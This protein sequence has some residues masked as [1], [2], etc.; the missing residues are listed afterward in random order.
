MRLS[1]GG[2]LRHPRPRRACAAGAVRAAA[3][4]ALLERLETRQL[5]CFIHDGVSDGIAMKTDGFAPIPAAAAAADAAIAAA[6]AGMPDLNSRPAAPAA[7]YL[8]FDGDSATSTTAY[9]D[10]ADAT[11]F[12]PAEA[13]IITRAWE[14]M[15]TYF[16]VFDVNIT[17]TQPAA[18][19]PTAWI[20]I[21]NNIAG[22]YSEVGPFPNTGSRAHSWAYSG[23]AR[24]RVSGIAHEIGHNFGLQHQSDFNNLGV[25]TREYSEGYD[26]LHG[27]IMG[28]DVSQN[29]HKWFIGHNSV[30]AT[31]LQDDLTL[32]ANKIKPYQPV[33]GDGYRV[34]DFAD[35]IAAATALTLTGTMFSGAG[36]IERSPDVDSFSFTVGSAAR[37]TQITAQPHLNSAVD[38]KL[39]LYA[40]DG[41]LV[42]AAD[43]AANAQDI[44]LTLQPGQYYV[45]LSSHG[46]YGDVGMYDVA[47]NALP[48]GW[49]QQD[50]GPIG[51]FGGSASYDAA[52]GTFNIR[53]N[54]AL[55]GSIT[56]DYFRYYFQTLNGDGSI[57]ARVNSIVTEQD[58]GSAGI[59]VRETLDTNSKYAYLKVM[60]GGGLRYDVRSATGS[61]GNLTI[62]P[63][64]AA[65]VWLRLT[66]AGTSLTASHS[67]N[68]VNWTVIDTRTL[69]MNSSV[70]VGMVVDS[71]YANRDATA[72]FSNV[73]LTGVLGP[74]TPPYNALPAPTNVT[75]APQP[76]GAGMTATWNDI[77]GETG[78]LIERSSDGVTFATAGTVGANVTSFN[79]N[80]LAGSMRYFYRVS[81]QS[82]SGRSAPSPV[83]H[84]VNRP[85]SVTNI[86]VMSITTQQVVVD[87][88]DTDGE[89]GYRVERSSD[90]GATW[91]FMSTLAANVPSYTATGLTQGTTYQ[92][93]VTPLSSVGDGPSATI[94][95]QSRLSAV[96]GL[97]FTSVQSNQVRLAWTGGVAFAT[98]YRVERSVDGTNFSTLANVAANI[99][100]YTDNTVTPLNK[101][102]YRVA[103]TNALT[104]SVTAASAK[105]ATPSATPLPTG[106]ATTDIGATPGASG[107]S[108]SIVTMI[109]SGALV[110]GPGADKF[111]YLFQRATGDGD[112]IARVATHEA[113]SVIGAGIMLRTS[114][115]DTSNYVHLRA[116]SVGM[117]MLFRGG[118]ISSAHI[119]VNAPLWFK[120]SRSGATVTGYYSTDGLSWTLVGTSTN[121]LAAT[122]AVNVGLLTTPQDTN[123]L[124]RATFDNLG[125]TLLNQPDTLPPLQPAFTSI[126]N[127][128]GSSGVDRVTADNTLVLSGNAEPAS[129]VTIT[130][131]AVGVVG[132]V[133]ANYL[134]NFS[135]DYSGVALADGVHTFTAT[136]R[137][138]W[139]NLS[140]TSN[141]FAV[142]ID[143]AAPTPIGWTFNVATQR[144]EIRYSES[145][146]TSTF[147]GGDVALLNLTTSQSP[148]TTAATYV[149][150]SNTGTYGTG[151]ALAD[152]HWRVTLNAAAVADPA[153][154][155]LVGPYTYEFYYAGGTS[156]ADAYLIRTAAGGGASIEVVKGAQTHLVPRAALQQI[157]LDPQAGTDSLHLD[158]SAGV[159]WMPPLGIAIGA[160]ESARITGG[161]GAQTFS[162]AG[163]V[164]SSGAWNVDFA[165]VQSLALAAGGFSLASDLGGRALSVESGAVV[166]AHATLRVSTLAIT[167]NS[168]VNLIDND[169]VVRNGS[170]ADV[171]AL[172]VSGALT[173]SL[174]SDIISTTLGIGSADDIFSLAAGETVL[175]S[176]QTVSGNDVLVKYTYQGDANLDGFVSGDDYSSIDFNIGIAGATGYHNG[177]FNHDGIISGDDYSSIDFNYT[178]QGAPL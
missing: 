4:A 47:I 131:T 85:S 150:A 130:R 119:N 49:M 100:S 17:T 62:V 2:R 59:M 118:T 104:E 121:A 114:L 102:F 6:A 50:V 106:W 60:K 105:I 46:N 89:N 67:T 124:V 169:L 163:N 24:T 162:F 176:G 170:V 30:S 54:V 25:K 93:R 13:A 125:G 71:A 3:T 122:G 164:L 53:A 37:P 75:I 66:R 166:D 110:T 155:T 16:G 78:Y 26:L 127:D 27:P 172:I 63:G 68:G 88:R 48:P 64:V 41:S 157:F 178:G 168:L 8:D 11:T 31:T 40:A 56:P 138:A 21:G 139:N 156:G 87:W 80:N 57:T 65:P 5:M 148:G 18:G 12:T 90:S 44:A 61:F 72:A 117:D 35:T 36:V 161:P 83:V 39:M 160:I 141:S 45:L 165:S 97:A 32:I 81:A 128:T 28:S 69:A 135:F 126:S 91:S 146:N 136:A 70:S 167:G 153:G 14:E 159:D 175:F 7:I 143:T 112:F 116:T 137:D 79:D 158:F 123:S 82:A 174:F 20:A 58:N 38:L 103:A 115:N 86:K 145:L 142:T 74:Q 77:S 29:V 111:H 152:G 19:F 177:D 108:G 73:A 107:F 154:N 52:S 55:A 94:A 92:F 151:A 84:A 10:D 9:S 76:S 140:A 95:A 109:G 133:Q 144:V 98:G 173:S 1:N 23:F 113:N 149:P 147:G 42:A 171:E 132:T 51:A 15:S 120:L 43:S 134:G 22:G 33:G 34:D 96:T 101:Y 129:W 99:S